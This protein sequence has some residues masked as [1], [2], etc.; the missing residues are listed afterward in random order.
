MDLNFQ[1]F[2]VNVREQDKFSAF[3]G[4]CEG[5]GCL[6]LCGLVLYESAQLSSKVTTVLHSYQ[7]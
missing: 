1:L 3:L 6:L 7:R 5:A 2:W 4:K